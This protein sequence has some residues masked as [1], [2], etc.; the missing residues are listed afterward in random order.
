MTTYHDQQHG[1]AP[2]ISQAV[3]DVFILSGQ[4]NMS[5]RGG[6]HTKHHKDGSIYKEWDHVVPSACH[7]EDGNMVLRLNAKQEWVKACEP[8]H[9]DIDKGIYIHVLY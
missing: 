7:I 6:V 1:E 8:L 2:L 5:G 3:T 9:Q 4:S